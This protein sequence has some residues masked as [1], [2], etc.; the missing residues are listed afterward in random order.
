MLQAWSQQSIVLNH[1][2]ADFETASSN[3]FLFCLTATGVSLLKQGDQKE[4][5]LPSTIVGKN[6]NAKKPKANK[7]EALRCNCQNKI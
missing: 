5:F 3:H 1:S 2:C 6:L 7:P 4:I